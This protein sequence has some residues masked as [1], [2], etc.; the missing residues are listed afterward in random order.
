[1]PVIIFGAGVGRLKLGVGLIS[2]LIMRLYD[3]TRKREIILKKKDLKK[4]VRDFFDFSDF[5]VD[6]FQ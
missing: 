1:M 2:G 5:F 4:G 3:I 6:F